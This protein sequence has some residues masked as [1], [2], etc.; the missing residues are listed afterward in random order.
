MN[1]LQVDLELVKKYNVAGPRYTSYPPATKF[2]DSIS[3]NDL[4]SRIEDNNRTSRDLSIYFHIPF[5]EITMDKMAINSEETAIPNL[6][7]MVNPSYRPPIPIT[8]FLKDWAQKSMIHPI[9]TRVGSIFSLFI[10]VSLLSCSS[11]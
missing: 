7:C 9:S 4:S 2:T 6:D 8:I 1:T 10:F 3:W 5:C 11:L